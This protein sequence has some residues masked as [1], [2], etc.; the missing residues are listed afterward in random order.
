MPN[1][2]SPD[3]AMSAF[4]VQTLRC[5]EAGLAAAIKPEHRELLTRM[6]LA[7]VD[8]GGM[9]QLIE[10]GRRRCARERDAGVRGQG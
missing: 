9:L 3:A 5:V 10:D 7:E 4:E 6:R 8:S 1:R 2:R